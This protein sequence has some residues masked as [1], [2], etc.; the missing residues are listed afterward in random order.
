MVTRPLSTNV[1][2]TYLDKHL[3]VFYN[4]ARI[5][6]AGEGGGGGVNRTV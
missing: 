5:A 4:T 3:A 2:H 1:Y 6:S